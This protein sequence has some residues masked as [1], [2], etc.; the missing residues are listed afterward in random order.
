MLAGRSPARKRREVLATPR[1]GAAST[2]LLLPCAPLGARTQAAGVRER[3]TEKPWVKV[4]DYCPG[5]HNVIFIRGSSVVIVDA[6][7]QGIQGNHKGWPQHGKNR[8]WM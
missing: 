2:S 5:C 8:S 3:N 1:R 7:P 6:G 4:L